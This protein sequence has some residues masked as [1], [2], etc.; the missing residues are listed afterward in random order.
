MPDQYE[1]RPMLDADLDQVAK[2]EARV[3][4]PGRFART[5]Y[6]LREGGR[7]RSKLCM[8]AWAGEKLAGSVR[9]IHIEI[10]KGCKAALL[11]PL[12]VAPEHTGYNLGIRLIK[13]AA[14]AARELN[15]DALILIGD[16][17]Y[18]GKAGFKPL[19][20]GRVTMPGPV[21]PSRL[22]IL[23]LTPEIAATCSGMIT[24]IDSE[25]T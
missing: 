19:P 14:T 8:S 6:R 5:A 9:L 17:P 23:E 15:L 12:N 1:I 7:Q 11:G 10:G 20:H 18:Y 2:L 21:D 4:G 25:A 3:Y 16:A 22:L 24:A 13:A